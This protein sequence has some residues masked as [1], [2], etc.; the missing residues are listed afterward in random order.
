MFSWAQQA[1]LPPVGFLTL[2]PVSQAL[3]QFPNPGERQVQFLNKLK[4]HN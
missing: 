3:A 2:F 4:S 1:P